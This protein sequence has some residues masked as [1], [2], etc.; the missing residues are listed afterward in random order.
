MDM[1]ASSAGVSGSLTAT[2][3]RIYG[4]RSIANDLQH[5]RKK[6]NIEVRVTDLGLGFETS[7]GRE[8]RADGSPA[9]PEHQIHRRRGKTTSGAWHR[10]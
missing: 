1:A 6:K 9:Q 10:T 4:R 8:G 3:H 5:K 2:R 7:C